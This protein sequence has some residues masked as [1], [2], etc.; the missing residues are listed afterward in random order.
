MNRR[1]R[2]PHARPC[3]TAVVLARDGSGKPDEQSR[4]RWRTPDGWGAQGT[5][6]AERVAVVTAN[7]RSLPALA[8][9]ALLENWVDEAE[10]RTWFVYDASR[11]GEPSG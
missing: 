11:Q 5:C 4:T 7:A 8:S 10:R 9:A 1:R 6:P 2:R 3:Q